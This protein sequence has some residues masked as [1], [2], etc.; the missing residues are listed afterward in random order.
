MDGTH[1]RSRGE[2]STAVTSVSVGTDSPPLARG[3]R[4]LQGAH[5]PGV[6]LTPARAGKARV[7]QTRLRRSG[8][9]PRSRG[10]GDAA[11]ASEVARADSPPLARGRPHAGH[12]AGG[13]GGLTPARAGKAYSRGGVPAR[14]RTHPRSRG[15]GAPITTTPVM[16]A[17]SPPLA[18]GRLPELVR[19]R[20]VHGLTPARAGKAL[21]VRLTPPSRRTH[22]RS[23]GEGGLSQGERA[24]P[25]DSPPLARG[26]L[27]PHRQEQ[28]HQGLTPAR[29]GKARSARTR[30]LVSGTHP[31]SRGEGGDSSATHATDPDSPPL[32]RG[33]L[34]PEPEVP[35]LPGLTPA[36]AGK[37]LSSNL[38][39]QDA[40]THPRS[41]G[42]GSDN[43]PGQR[44]ELDSPPL[45]RGRPQ[46][47]GNLRASLGLT[48]ARAGKA[49]PHPARPSPP[50][51]HP[52]S[53]GEGGIE[54]TTTAHTT[55]SPPLARGRPVIGHRHGQPQGLTPARA[56]KAEI[57]QRRTPLI[58][59]HPRSRGE[60][61]FKKWLDSPE[62]DS[63]PLARG[64]PYLT[65]YFT[66]R[67]AQPQC[68]P[69]KT[70]APSP[71]PPAVKL[72]AAGP[73]KPILSAPAS[74]EQA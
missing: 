5:H 40:G 58:R 2:G 70:L 8:T 48:P 16:C 62:E 32:A 63:P 59:T 29:A 49:P 47:L 66:S 20:R 46:G 42:E 28:G 34:R 41:R 13:H 72:P 37:A 39:A 35:R 52:R 3:R 4:L 57:L 74:S 71:S 25:Q 33:R 15:E 51:T 60:G 53:R 61:H 38:A 69:L 14:G 19:A 45:A 10:E 55:D 24:V 31:R 22:P 11:G 17:D 26:R 18:R 56:G 9:H 1:P 64:R 6:G 54:P 12:G 21:R 43:W 67:L 23:R 30:P 50:W 7:L 68:F 65:C 27:R 36:R 73:L 44:V